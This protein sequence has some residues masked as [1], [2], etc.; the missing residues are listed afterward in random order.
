MA[1]DEKLAKRIRKALDDE[2]S[3]TERKMFGGLA[4]LNDGNM[5]CGI[6]GERLMLR[7]G[8]DR[9][10]QALGKPHVKPMD[11]TGRPLRGMVYIEPEGIQGTRLKRWIQW[12][13][14]FTRSLPAKHPDNPRGRNA[15]GKAVPRRSG[16]ASEAKN[17][18]HEKTLARIQAVK[19]REAQSNR[20]QSKKAQPNKPASR[21]KARR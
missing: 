12:G 2:A 20:A 19:N 5:C 1:Y 11:F 9:H 18:T 14:E 17:A 3:I 6:V 10:E 15:I 8:P 21:P 7:V 13:L 4:F 16:A